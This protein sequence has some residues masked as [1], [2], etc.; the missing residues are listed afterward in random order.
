[1]DAEGLE[2]PNPKGQIYS[3]PA[4]PICIDIQVFLLYHKFATFVK[5]F[6][7]INSL[8]HKI[9]TLSS[10]FCEKNEIFLTTKGFIKEMGF[11]G[12]S[13]YTTLCIQSGK[14]KRESC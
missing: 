14:N 6:F 3:L 8:Y 4:L 1:M 11:W 13:P 5:H 12:Y 10:L 9:S 7:T 2:P